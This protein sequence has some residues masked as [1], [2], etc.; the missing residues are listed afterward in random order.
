MLPVYA[1]YAAAS[2]AINLSFKSIRYYVDKLFRDKVTP[3]PGSALYC[4]LFFAVEHSG[5]YIDDGKISNIEV[6]GIADAAVR[7][8][9]PESFTSKSV[10]GKAI[11]VSCDK[12]GAVGA[13]T[14]AN[15]AARSVGQRSFY[16]LVVKNCHEF[17]TRCVEQAGKLIDDIP[18]ELLHWFSRSDWEPTISI[19]KQAAYTH[20]GATK[21]RLWD[22]QSNS[23]DTPQEPDWEAI[24]QH[25][26]N[27]PLDEDSIESIRSDLALAESYRKEI[28][29][30][31]IPDAVK[32]RLEAFCATA[33][34]VSDVYEQAKPFLA[35]CKGASL[36]CADLKAMNEDFTSLA[37]EMS[38]NANIHELARKLG[39]NHISEA[40]KRSVRI[41]EAGR[42]EVYGIHRSGDVMRLLPS[43]LIH[44]EDDS[45]EILFYARL[46]ENNL[47]TYELGG[48]DYRQGET[49]ESR[50]KRTGP[51]VACLDTSGSML[52]APLLK[53]KA[54]LLT[55]ASILKREDRSLYILL[56]GSSGEIRE[57]FINQE[58]DSKSII[59]FINQGFG[60]G[61]D[62]ETPLTRSMEIIESEK[63]FLKADIL[64]ITDGQCSLSKSFTATI[65][66][67]K[68]VH[69]CSI[70]T[71]L[72]AGHSHG[73][74]IN[75]EVILI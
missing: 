74:D 30:E 32:R 50:S 60:G 23:S 42:N 35:A 10:L 52:G 64:M 18:G 58:N 36:S 13:L 51:V 59:S 67:K 72:C 26:L 21:W 3:V 20:L 56:F 47:L 15:I 43:E 73:D 63:D 68:K 53:A 57:L 2:T 25:L 19:L 45:L 54:L 8:C 66:E 5:I 39:R 7:L 9:G 40:L 62:F 31:N 41:P 69:D 75:D 29:D 1:G 65:N 44:F 49:T 4:D 37:A 6:E 11:Y 14:T 61:T 55:V 17:S 70:Y 16:G 48:T 24:N 34:E 12:H 22:W 71:V 46:L 28:S 38:N 27:T 33:K